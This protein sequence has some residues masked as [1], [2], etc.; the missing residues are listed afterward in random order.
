M[1]CPKCGR[2]I[3]DGSK[4]CILCGSRIIEKPELNL[5]M[6]IAAEVFNLVRYIHGID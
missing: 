4:F 6:N 5:K 3:E 1:K 2:G